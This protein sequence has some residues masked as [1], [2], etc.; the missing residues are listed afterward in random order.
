MPKAIHPYEVLRRPIVT[1][2]STM[3]AGQGKYVFEVAKHANK[4]QI[5]EAVQR[6]FNVTVTAVNTTI[7]RGRRK[8]NRAGR[9]AGTPPS[10]KKAIVTLRAGDEIQLFEGV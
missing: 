1:E 9:R 6:A 7:V 10:W 8:R 5:Q 4:P 3:L 2:K